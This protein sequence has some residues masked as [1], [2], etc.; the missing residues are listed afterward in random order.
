MKNSPNYCIFLLAT[1]MVLTFNSDV[2][3]SPTRTD[4]RTCGVLSESLYYLNSEILSHN[5]LTY[6]MYGKF[7][8]KGES[9]K[10]YWGTIT[11]E[12]SYFWGLD[13]DSRVVTYLTI[14]EYLTN[15]KYETNRE[16][17]VLFYAFNRPCGK[18]FIWLITPNEILREAIDLREIS[19]D[20]SRFLLPQRIGKALIDKSI[21]TLIVVPTESIGTI[22]FSS[23]RLDTTSMVIDKMSVFISPGFHTFLRETGPPRSQ[24]FH[25]P[26]IVGYGGDGHECDQGFDPIPGAEEAAVAI[27]D[28]LGAQAIT[29]ENAT[30]KFIVEAI[31]P[32]T[33]LIFLSTHGSYHQVHPLDGG[34]LLLH[35]QQPP[36]CTWTAREIKDLGWKIR[37]NPLVV[38]SACKTGLGKN[39]TSGTIGLARAWQHAGAYDVVMSLWEVEV[40][41]TK[42]LMTRFIPL[43]Q[44]MAPDKALRKAMLEARRK[45]RDSNKWAGFT[46]F[47][48]PRR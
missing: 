36:V 25:Q 43:A 23:L 11:K 30:K 18:L 5:T 21:D 4:H 3:A 46:M 37:N 16:A 41:P 9:G 35:P 12:H 6:R 10:I 13:P 7:S 47:G 28:S 27:A 19:G 38:M 48:M 32:E 39:F 1:I 42:F 2:I 14:Q 31:K 8:V 15:L 34:F 22:S 45:Y 40:D 17:A 24:I 33:G 26:V 20:L 29:G 44:K